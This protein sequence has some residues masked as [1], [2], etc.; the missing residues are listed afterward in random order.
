[1]LSQKLESEYPLAV[2][3]MDV[4]SA[5]VFGR[6]LGDAI[7]TEFCNLFSTFDG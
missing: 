5:R 1:M 3:S 6:R 2:A 7:L 4:P